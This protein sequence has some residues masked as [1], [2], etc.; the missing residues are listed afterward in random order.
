MAVCKPGLI[1]HQ[2]GWNP[3][4]HYEFSES[5]SYQSSF[6]LRKE[7]SKDCMYIYKYRTYFHKIHLPSGLEYP[8]EIN[9]K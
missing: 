9:L 6:S 7:T 5:L 4:L 3:E 8:L 1:M 2:H